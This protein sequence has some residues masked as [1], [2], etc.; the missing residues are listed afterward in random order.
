[1]CPPVGDTPGG[2]GV[3][4]I[5]MFGRQAVGMA[6]VKSG[7]GGGPG[8]GDC[9]RAM[10]MSCL[11]PAIPGAEANPDAKRLY[12]DL[13]SN[14]N[15]LIRPV[16]NNSDRL[17]VKMGLRLSQLID[18]NLKN[19]IMTTNVWV[20][21][22]WNDYKLKWNPDD[23]GGVDTLHVP[24][25]HIWLPDI[26]LYNNADGNYE[27]TIMTK[28]ILHHT[29][30]V[31][32][33]PPAI[34]KSFCE[35]D[36]EYFPFDE[37][38]CFMKFGSWTYD[39][40]TVDLRH[41]QQSEDSNDIDLGIDLTDYYI[42]VEWDIIK[43][44][45]V[46]NEKFYI[47][48]EEPYP[49]IMFYITLR[50]KTLFYT[51]NLIIPCVGISF[52]SVLVFYL[53]SD[54]GEKVSL[55]ISILL[56][57]TV[58]FLLLAEII[59]PTSLTVPLLGKYLL[60]TMVLVTFSVVV[61]IAVLNVN[62]RSPVT[63]RMAKWVRVVFIQ[64]LPKF[65]LIERP[66]KDDPTEGDDDG[67]PSDGILTDV[68]HLPAEMEKY[69]PYGA[70]RYSADYDVPSVPTTRFDAAPIAV[71]ATM[72]PCFD[73]P[74]PA[75][76]LPGADDDLFSPASPGCGHDDVSPTFE[77]PMIREIEKT[78]EDARFIAQHA[79]NKDKFES[80]E[81][82]WKY[83]A[84]VLDRIFLWLFTLAC[85]LGTALIILQAPSLYDT[86]KPIDIKYSKIAKKKM[87]LMNMGPEED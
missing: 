85:V 31:V 21:Q 55:S 3:R 50:R 1:M 41:L 18:V 77:K 33:K 70:K 79:K 36:V 11:V 81:E 4:C 6:V 62:F 19:Q 39:G 34:Y 45:A 5:E 64:V 67:K 38:T 84:M 15:R 87:M 22:E 2:Q 40:Y 23:Y 65:L 17:T 46:R 56:S 72:G 74:H 49:D 16:G 83:V 82:D 44:P 25:E 14:Y 54:S 7:G 30:K 59:P 58:F 8:W 10:A 35:I 69:M 78:V 63:H 27:V 53:P 28:A 24:S 86:T 9:W 61:T 47:C 26:V 68:F 75:L 73:E 51:V 12:D 32:W 20:E 71:V 13:L 66:K 43:V 76:P 80:V 48:C 52:L 57:L 29:G 37:Q 60:F 42:S